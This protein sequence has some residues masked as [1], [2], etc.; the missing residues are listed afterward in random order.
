MKRLE[1]SIFLKSLNSDNDLAKKSVRGGMTTLA[2]QGTQFA[3]RM[4]GMLILVRILSPTDYGVMAMAMIVLNFV[5]MFKDAGLSMATVQRENISHDQISTLFWLNVVISALIA[6]LVLLGA[7]LLSVFFKRP[8]LTNVLAA[9][10]ISILVSGLAIQHEALLRRHL[11]FN[12]LAFIQIVS[13][14]VNLIISVVLALLGF[15]YWALIGGAIFQSVAGT[16]M[17]FYFCP[18][19]PGK[20]KRGAGVRDMLKFGGHLTG[21]NFVN[22]F[23][24]NADNLLI[25]RF[26]GA[27]A[28]G[29]YSRAYQLLMMP[30]TLI[31]APLDQVAM[32]ALS[33][34][35]SKPKHYAKYYQRLLEVSILVMMPVTLLCALEAEFLVRLLLGPQ[36]VGTVAVFRI[37][38]LA[39]LI[40]AISSTR[41]LVLIS[42]GYSVRYFYWGLFNSILMVI[43]F[44]VGLSFGIEGVAAA[45][46]IANCIILIPSLFYCFRG[47]PVTVALFLRTFYPPLLAA[48]P[49]AAAIMLAKYFWPSSSLLMHCLYSCIFI[50][51]FILFSWR[52][53]S[54]R[55]TVSLVLSG[56]RPDLDKRMENGVS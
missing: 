42:S 33:S 21:F 40:Q 19:L 2:A 3:L 18:W 10:S 46:T 12:A 25:G 30:I 15:R 43:S 44:V 7:P 11:R 27:E 37:F 9:I 5:Q 17:T 32:P 13:L 29:F 8:E 47:T 4:A 24:R 38:A 16:S 6:F 49:A 53:Q 55:E 56:L 35:R 22:Y 45:Y 48:I 34:L 51:T 41:G 28:L 14:V 36:W 54:V 1:R 52:R 31:R 26:I 20:M 23:A 50:G 39:G